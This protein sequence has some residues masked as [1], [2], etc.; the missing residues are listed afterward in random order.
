M[1]MEFWDDQ[2]R[3]KHVHMCILVQNTLFCKTYSLVHEAQA[4][5]IENTN[6]GIHFIFLPTILSTTQSSED[7]YN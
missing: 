2:T 1:T 4:K 5:N 3:T 6:L 7:M